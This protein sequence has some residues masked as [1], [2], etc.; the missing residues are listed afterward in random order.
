MKFIEHLKKAF[1]PKSTRSHEHQVVGETKVKDLARFWQAE[2]E[3]INVISARGLYDWI[4][5]RDFTKEELRA[6][7]EG[8]AAIPLFMKSCDD[9]IQK[10]AKE[11]ELKNSLKIK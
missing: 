4:S 6:F 1:I 9:W 5:D 8:L 7:K 2:A 3:T 11:A 10:E